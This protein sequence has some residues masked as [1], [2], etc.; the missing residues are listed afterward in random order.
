M[1]QQFD[2]TGMPITPALE[3]PGAEKIPPPGLPEQKQGL[4]GEGIRP[5]KSEAWWEQVD[6]NALNSIGGT[7]G[8]GGSAVRWLQEQ[9]MADEA[10]LYG[11]AKLTADQANRLYP[12]M[13]KPFTEDVLPEVAAARFA[14]IQRQRTMQDWISR[15]QDKLSW[16]NNLTAGLAATAIS[17][18]DLGAGLLAGEVIGVGTKALGLARVGLKGLATVYGENL[19]GNLA[20]QAPNYYLKKQQGQ[21]VSVG[22]EVSNAASNALLFTGI[23]YLASG[24][25]G[26]IGKTPKDLQEQ[27]MREAIAQHES[28]LAID[29]SR[30]AETAAARVEGKAKG[31]AVYN[32]G[33]MGH[34]SERAFYQGVSPDTQTPIDYGGYGD[35]SYIDHQT[36]AKNTTTN[37]EG[38]NQG[39]TVE[40]QI[41]PDTK[42]LDLENK[43]DTPEIMAVAKSIESKVGVDL[44]LT[45]NLSLKE[46]IERVKEAGSA[47]D[48]PQMMAKAKEAAQS[49]GYDGYQYTHDLNGSP[50][51]NG[52]TLFDQ[53]NFTP[54]LE[55]PVIPGEVPR[56][57]TDPLDLSTDNP[58][59][60]ESYDPVKEAQLKT[61]IESMPKTE[62]QSST[63]VKHQESVARRMLSAPD[64]P[65]EV[66][67]EVAAVD[68]EYAEAGRV[69]K[70]IKS[71]ADCFIR[72]VT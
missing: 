66:H 15:S 17:P 26:L 56:A 27:G 65:A 11:T 14:N 45:P 63:L 18:L 2:Q 29:S 10:Q 23:H 53:Q 16:Y 60:M 42:L 9:R 62:E 19:A 44:E 69:Q 54:S 8:Y 40:G 25:K 68:R 59:R 32:V 4:G 57:S 31:A 46:V 51:H 50:H 5:S 35:Q 36:V 20:L 33:E 72:G 39:H 58:T 38:P 1:A 30:I 49:M 13:E 28:G 34:P 70:A 48:E 24:L 12:G 37:P 64:T 67:E 3:P 61:E 21:E 52:V 47:K 41:H 6:L 71:F 7:I 43:L 55:Q 22:E